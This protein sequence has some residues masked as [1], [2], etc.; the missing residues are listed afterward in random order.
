MTTARESAFVGAGEGCKL[1]AV[2]RALVR[3]AYEYVTDA[4]PAA[5]RAGVKAAALRAPQ[6]CKHVM[7]PLAAKERRGLTVVLLLTSRCAAGDYITMKEGAPHPV[8]SSLPPH[9]TTASIA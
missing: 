9:T 6:L 5:Q 7:D 2:W 3:C 4:T 1:A 8:S